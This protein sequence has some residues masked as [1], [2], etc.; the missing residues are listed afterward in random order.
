MNRNRRAHERYERRLHVVLVHEGG[1]ID[2][3]TRNVSLGG[4]LLAT[5]ASLRFGTRVRLRVRLPALKADTD[6]EATVR[7]SG[8]DSLGVQF[9]SLR[10]IEVW[11]LNQ[12]F[13]EGD[14]S[15]D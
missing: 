11:A 10:A 14:G 4:M 12:L 15:L 2:C 8:D 1:E 13:K 5:S 6:I 9:G 7:W 3:V